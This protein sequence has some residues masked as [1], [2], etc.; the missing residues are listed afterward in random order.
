[1]QLTMDSSGVDHGSAGLDDSL[2][3]I[4]KACDDNNTMKTTAQPCKHTA[5]TCRDGTQNVPPHHSSLHCAK[6]ADPHSQQLY[7]QQQSHDLAIAQPCKQSGSA[8]IIIKLCKADPEQQWHKLTSE[9]PVVVPVKQPP[10]SPEAMAAMRRTLMQQRQQRA[11]APTHH[12][13]AIS[14]LPAS[15]SHASANQQA[16]LDAKASISALP[17]ALSSLPALHS[18][19]SATQEVSSD[20]KLDVNCLPA[21]LSS[22]PALHSNASAKQE[23]TSCAKADTSALPTAVST[24]S[25]IAE[26]A[27]QMMVK[28]SGCQCSALAGLQH[29]LAQINGRLL[30]PESLCT[31]LDLTSSIL[32]TCMLPQPSHKQ[33]L[34]QILLAFLQAFCH[35]L[36]LLPLS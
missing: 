3:P 28:P 23:A 15:R 12:S 31:L 13:S 21:P 7:Q 35:L 11:Q 27:A 4:D 17:A 16:S 30:Q 10:A 22:L 20:V 18:N 5:K 9:A 8:A 26:L 36:H 25:D 29:E 14:G 1:M 19:A 6:Q 24:A 32:Q 2:H 33:R 34:A